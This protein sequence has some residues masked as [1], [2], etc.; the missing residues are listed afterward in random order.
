MVLT[1]AHV[2]RKKSPLAALLSGG[3]ASEDCTMASSAK[4]KV[5]FAI[6]PE[7]V[8]RLE[9]AEILP[10]PVVGCGVTMIQVSLAN[11]TTW[12]STSTMEDTE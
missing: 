5:S 7:T 4:S 10:A 1:S 3:N 2:A 6:V 12:P 11:S 9:F 8:C